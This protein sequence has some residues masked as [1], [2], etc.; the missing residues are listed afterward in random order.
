MQRHSSGALLAACLSAGLAIAQ[1]HAK[2]E[3]EKHQGTW[4][5]V[6]FRRDGQE[7]PGEIVR[8]ISRIVENDHVVWKRNGKSF[9]GTIMV[10]DPGQ[11]PKAIDVIP[12][13]GPSR[14]KHVLGIYLLEDDKLTLCMADADQPRP[15]EFKAEKGSRQTLMTLRRE[16]KQSAP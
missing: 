13:G 3:L 4:I 15:R 5:A 6:S 8:T 1:E 9:A 7:T 16:K 11:V 12:D 2:Q 10:L 14:G